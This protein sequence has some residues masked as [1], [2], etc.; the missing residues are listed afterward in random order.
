MLVYSFSLQSISLLQ[1]FIRILS[2]RLYH[3]SLGAA[4]NVQGIAT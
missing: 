4:R 3:S 2:A 1:L